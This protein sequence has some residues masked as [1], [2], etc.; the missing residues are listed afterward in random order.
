MVLGK[1]RGVQRIEKENGLGRAVPIRYDRLGEDTNT[2]NKFREH[3]F[4]EK[5]SKE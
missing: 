1:T 4:L 3:K 5:M 2:F